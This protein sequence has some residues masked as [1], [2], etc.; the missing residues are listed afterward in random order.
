MS[1]QTSAS[2][3]AAVRAVI[4]THTQAQDSGD[5]DGVIA[6]YATDAV[7]EIPGMDTIA[8][9]DALR[10][11]FEGWAPVAPQRHMVANTLVTSDG[12]DEA[13]AISDVVF[14]LRG[15]AGWAPQ[16]VGRY[17][18]TLRQID[19]AWLIQNRKTIYS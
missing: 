19:G 5:T 13:T 18:D 7:L 16:I 10:A 8:G 4:G 1:D 15:E 2:V 12:D 14:F 17:E 9:H 6:T 3:A 11:A